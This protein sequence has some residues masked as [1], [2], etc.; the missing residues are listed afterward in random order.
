MSRY[1]IERRDETIVKITSYYEY[2][3]EGEPTRQVNVCGEEYAWASFEENLLALTDQPLSLEFLPDE[4]ITGSEFE[5]V[6]QR[7]RT[8]GI[9]ASPDYFYLKRGEREKLRN[10]VEK[11]L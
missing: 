7:A 8:F 4:E 9:K 1:F 5:K 6:W 2:D 11:G 3:E 10:K